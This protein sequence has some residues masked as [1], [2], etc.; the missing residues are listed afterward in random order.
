MSEAGLEVGVDRSV[1][2]RVAARGTDVALL[3]A[4]IVPAAHEGEDELTRAAALRGA[5]L[6]QK[7][8]AGSATLAVAGKDAIVRYI[9][10]PVAPPWRI[11]LL[12]DVEV[13]D[14]EEKA[15]EPLSSDYRLLTIPESLG[16]Q[17]ADEI[18]CL[19]ALAKEGPLAARIAALRA[20]GVATARVLPSAVALFDAFVGLGHVG[21]G[22]TVALIDAGRDAVELAL[23]REGFLV[24]ARSLPHPP[25]RGRGDLSSHDAQQLAGAIA[26]SVGLARSQMKLRA[27]AAEEVMVSGAHARSPALRAALK[28]ALKVEPAV[29][30]PLERLET[31]RLDPRALQEIGDRGP[32][33]AIAVGLALAAGHPRAL[34]LDVRPRA[35]KARHEF[36]T[37][38]VFLYAGGALLAA[39]L[40][41]SAIAALAARSGALARRAKLRQTLAALEDRRERLDAE[42][43]AN[44]R[45]IQTIDALSKRTQPGA[46]L[47]RLLERLRLATPPRVT[48]AEVLL[49]DAPRAA[50][51]L[52][53]GAPSGHEMT[54]QREKAGA[55]V[56][57]AFRLRG[58][59]D[60]A[61]GEADELLRKLEDGLRE[62]PA[63]ISAK[64]TGT[65]VSRPDATREFVLGVRMRGSAAGEP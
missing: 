63:V 53:R 44:R 12:M 20:A 1:F 46:A 37:R 56:E 32:E 6:E 54:A 58:E 19:I 49:E 17:A 41:F 5:L 26:A 43:A 7:A 61:S 25:G 11:R 34:D 50:D 59:V 8:K 24:F 35:E 33:L 38:T 64:V 52:G 47:V 4:A 21:E 22:K 51:R 9:H 30:D 27:L 14:V 28:Q 65:P 23:V 10:L 60:N 3:H 36:A 15:G 62:D 42:R 31:G 48:I 2:V 39:A 40:L 29:F 16:P 13:R 55:P 45:T 57:V 18:P